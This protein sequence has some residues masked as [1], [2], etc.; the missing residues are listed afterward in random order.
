MCANKSPLVCARKALYR[1]VSVPKRLLFCV[2]HRERKSPIVC[3]KGPSIC[4]PDR[5]GIADR[6]RPKGSSFCVPQRHKQN[7]LLHKERGLCQIRPLHCILQKSR[8]APAPTREPNKKNPIPYR[9]A[10]THKRIKMQVS[11]HKTATNC[12]ALLRKT[13]CRRGTSL[14]MFATLWPKSPVLCTKSFSSHV[15]S[16]GSD[17]TNARTRKLFL[18]IQSHL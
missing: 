8:A 7:G 10:E 9:V 11:F 15:S 12:R 4:V 18:F 5:P 1:S 3:P 13:T 2:Q 17:S 16:E 6:V 14:C